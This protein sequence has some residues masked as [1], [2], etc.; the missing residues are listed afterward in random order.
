VPFGVHRFVRGGSGGQG[1]GY[2]LAPQELTEEVQGR[3]PL[4]PAGPPHRHQDGL[5]PRTC[6]GP[7]AAS[8]LAQDDA[9]ADGQ[10][11][12]SGDEPEPMARHP[13]LADLPVCLAATAGERAAQGL[14]EA[15]RPRRF[16]GVWPRGPAFHSDLGFHRARP[17]GQ[18]EGAFRHRES[19]RPRPRCAPGRGRAEGPLPEP[20]ADA[21]SLG[22]GPV[23]ADQAVSGCCGRAELAGRA[24]PRRTNWSAA[25]SP[26]SRRRMISGGRR[27]SR[28]HVHCGTAA[29]SGIATDWPPAD[30]DRTTY[31]GQG[32]SQEPGRVPI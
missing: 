9:E 21:R 8:D 20:A 12:R 22:G 15:D 2:R 30:A 13:A 3:A 6:P 26:I 4:P 32:G 19:F 28:G 5:R 29:P 14:K 24:G 23:D 16:L 10:R 11:L 31:P 7:A 25:T 18:W 27:G 1:Q 17:P